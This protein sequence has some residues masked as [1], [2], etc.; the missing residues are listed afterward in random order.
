MRWLA[1]TGFRYR[2][3][4]IRLGH[5]SSGAWPNV[6]PVSSRCTSSGAGTKAIAAEYDLD[7]S[8]VRKIVVRAKV[9]VTKSVEAKRD[10]SSPAKQVQEPA[11]PAA[12]ATAAAPHST[13]PPPSLSAGESAASPALT[14]LRD[15][16]YIA[17]GLSATTMAVWRAVAEL[18]NK[19]SP[20]CSTGAIAK[21]AGT[22]APNASSSLSTLSNRG[23]VD[24]SNRRGHWVITV[25][26]PS[27]ALP[28]PPAPRV[29]AVTPLISKPPAAKAAPPPILSSIVNLDQLMQYLKIKGHKVENVAGYILIDSSPHAPREA[30]AVANKYRKASDLDPFTL[31]KRFMPA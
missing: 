19:S 25:E 22:L 9:G 23:A 11:V 4:A 26:P 12:V 8:Q 31:E 14:P 16:R 24:R 10:D 21:R 20:D 2:R 17:I 7:A 27:G 1:V 6:T 28:T 15:P 5:R 3:A 18:C 30:L 13:H 29:A